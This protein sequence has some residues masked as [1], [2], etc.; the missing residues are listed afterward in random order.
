MS[1]KLKYIYETKLSNIPYIFNCTWQ[2]ILTIDLYLRCQGFFDRFKCFI[3]TIF[4]Y[5]VHFP[6]LT[7]LLQ[8][9]VKLYEVTIK[10]LCDYTMGIFHISFIPFEMLLIS[11]MCEKFFRLYTCVEHVLENFLVKT[12]LLKQKQFNWMTKICYIYMINQYRTYQRC[13]WYLCVNMF[14]HHTPYKITTSKLHKIH[15]YFTRNH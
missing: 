2:K 3:D 11:S 14:I 7:L 13:V 6:L 15:F 1:L 8:N 12:P 4:K 9:G 10:Q 5:E